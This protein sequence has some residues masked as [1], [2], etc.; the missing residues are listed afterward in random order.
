MSAVKAGDRSRPTQNFRNSTRPKQ[1]LK[2]LQG[3]IFAEIVCGFHAVTTIC[4]S[5]S[6]RETRN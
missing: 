1:S 5:F 2:V 6:H 3:P 4:R